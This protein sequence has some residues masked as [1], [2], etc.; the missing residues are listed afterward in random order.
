[1]F[2]A[3]DHWQSR[4]EY[5]AGTQP[6][7]FLTDEEKKILMGKLR[8][9]QNTADGEYLSDLDHVPMRGSLTSF[10]AKRRYQRQLCNSQAKGHR[11]R[12]KGRERGLQEK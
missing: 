4:R 12:S 1:M 6:A 5:G 9:F 2:R 10:P 3:A 8:V 11:E 7:Q